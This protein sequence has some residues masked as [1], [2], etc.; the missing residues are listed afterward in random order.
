MFKLIDSFKSII[1]AKN[2]WL[3]KD[4]LRNHKILQTLSLLNQ[5]LTF[6]HTL[7][8]RVQEA[9]NYRDTFDMD[10]STP[11][12]V[13]VTESYSTLTKKYFTNS[14][15]IFAVAW[16]LLALSCFN[17]LWGSFTGAFL[18]VRDG[19]SSLVFTC[20]IYFS[21]YSI[22]YSKDFRRDKVSWGCV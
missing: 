15:H 1:Y 9:N 16:A 10:F 11:S 3:S 19:M 2:Y 22:K 18:L 8:S 7:V 6:R 12:G 17:L 20:V 14:V 21:Y 4:C 13:I 5:I